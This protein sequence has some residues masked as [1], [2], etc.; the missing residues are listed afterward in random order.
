MIF[1][2][3][4]VNAQY[5]IN[6]NAAQTECNCWRLT[7]ASNGQNGSVWNVNLF[8]LSNPFNF[9]FDVYLGCN[10]G[11]AD[12][13]AFVLQPLNVNAGSSGGGMGYAGIN[14]SFAVEM[15]T[16]QNATDPGFDHM[17]F[18][19]NGSTSHG[20]GNTLAGPVQ[21]S[22]TSANV[23]DCG[24][25]QLNIVWD[26]ITM[27][28]TAYFDGVLRLSYTGD[29]INNLFGGN[30]NVYWGFTAATGGANNLH[31]F[32]N[33]LSPAFIIT[34]PIQCE[35]F[36]V[37]FESASIVATGLITDYQWDFGDGS[38]A[39][40]TQVSHL[41][42]TPGNYTVTLTI[43]SEGCTESSSVQVTINPD[44]VLD[45]GSDQS[46]CD[47]DSYQITATGLSGGEQLLWDPVIGLDNLGNSNPIATPLTTTV[48]TLGVIDA[49]GC[50]ASDDIEIIV[51]PLPVANAGVDQEICDDEATTMDGSGGTQYSWTPTA[52]LLDAT[53]ANSLANPSAT[54][55]YTLTV[56]DA[57]NCV[58]TD[59]M[60]ITVNALPIV[61]A[62]LDNSICDEQTLQLSAS[63]AQDYIWAPI[64]NLDNPF[65]SNP[66]LSGSSTTMF[67]VT[68][69]DA[70]GCVNTDDVEITVFPLP[71]ANFAQPQEV[72]LG[73][74]TVFT[75][76]SVG[77]GLIYSWNFGDGSPIDNSVS[78]VHTYLNDGTFTVNLDITDVNGCQ[79]S[80]SSTAVVF[81]LPNAAMNLFDG[82][83]FCENE[84]IQ[85]ENQSTGGSLDLFWNFGDNDFLPAF[86]NTTSTLSNPTMAYNNF[87]FGPYT[88]F[89]FVT[90]AAGCMD[91]TQT[92][93]IIHDNPSA[94]FASNIVCEGNETQFTDESSV[95][96]SNIDT[97]NWY[98][99]DGNG[100]S[101]SQNPFYLY[102]D[103]GT[104]SVQLSVETDDGCSAFFNQ[105]VLVNPTPEISISGIDTCLND[106][107]AFV[108]N[109]SPQ[110]NTIAS[111][112]WDFGDATIF[113][114]IDAVHTYADHGDFTVSLT[115]TS[116][117][118]C[119]ASGNTSVS[120]F[121]NPEPAFDLVD[122]EGCT[123]HEVLF[124]NQSTLATGLLSTYAW[125]FGEGSFSTSPNPVF[126]Y[127]DSGYYDITLSA[128]SAEGCNTI[129][130]LDD[131]VRAN[132]TPNADFSVDED[133]LSLLEAE[134]VFTDESEH[135][136]AWNWNFGDGTTSTSVNP[137]HVYTEPGSFDVLL[138]VTND[139]C[140]DV[141]FNQVV[142]E[143]IVSFYIPT[144]F[145][146]DDDG[147]N[148]SFFGTG[149]S[150][151]KYNMKIIDRWG[152]L[153]FESNEPEFHWD[154]TYKGKQVEMGVYAYS[155][156]LLDN[157][158]YEHRYVGH[159]TLLR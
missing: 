136:L 91:E 52:D 106:E 41:Y 11:G 58:D 29:I 33:S 115:A 4:G 24:W 65:I 45:L 56:T 109:S 113:N 105:E 104:F 103:S 141:A 128:T 40:G 20:G 76:N 133:R 86:P 42:A 18:Q 116:D 61:N 68:G 129:L 92:T 8:N 150:I 93:I 127:Q 36:P 153:L 159:V 157:F 152:M 98:F 121:P 114:G 16:Y 49:N 137:V 111:W 48:Y 27:T 17:A 75:D 102:G 147:I 72:C 12:G 14:P 90:D 30:P 6:G 125:D 10:D 143:P 23:E 44:P 74:P 79:A 154:G 62:G 73:N 81:P 13:L 87:A 149:E 32:C 63:G 99:G 35:G 46:I 64:A 82:Q 144:A 26:P 43:T 53:S 124:V 19:S 88:V 51:N 89:L 22:A 117:S 60:T 112:D 7:T 155:F 69:T 100:T 148:E 84:E 15:D 95:F 101:T 118:G 132:I 28:I 123:P 138:S 94:N 85:F 54:T 78:P 39:T 47:G 37:D 3:L 131:A 120:V 142:V 31:Q 110:D 158:G 21:T 71:T 135:G 1:S 25:H 34:S 139:D 50:T 145:T 97:W 55:N 126:T 122:A 5:Q 9:T 96:V 2:S 156:L 119:V 134:A 57:N 146:P 108:N 151:K 67:T 38:T 77:N 130:F 70:N 66:I 80:S 59:D 140:E 107:T 83:E